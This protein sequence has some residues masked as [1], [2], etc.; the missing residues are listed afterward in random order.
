MRRRARSLG[1]AALAAAVAL[2]A[3][4]RAVH[5][6]AA[7]GS[8]A[9]ATISAAATASAAP[10]AGSKTPADD[11]R[12][13]FDRGVTAHDQGKLAVAHEMFERAWEIKRTWDVAANLGILEHKLGRNVQAAEHLSFALAGL[14]PSEEDD[15]RKG[16]EDELAP[17]LAAV[18]KI[19]VRTAVPGAEVRVDGETKGVTPLDGPVF[20]APGSKIVV[21]LRK[22]GYEPASQRIEAK[23]G[24]AKDV[25]FVM[26]QLPPRTERSWRAPAV[27]FGFG[28]AGLVA[29]VAAGTFAA[30]RLGELRKSCDPDLVCP[31]SARRDAEDGRTAAHLATAGAALAGAGLAVGIVLLVV[32]TKTTEARVGLS[33]GPGVLSLEGAF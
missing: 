27:A 15:V 4:G 22:D 20:A 26:R 19:T 3:E 5:A 23:A 28:A 6:Q 17:V 21:E 14:P 9:H 25:S 2:L 1:P 24:E 10:Q 12:T 18:V 8:A 16:L 29:A 33:V 31:E 32:P 13:Y 11:A 30:V 7:K